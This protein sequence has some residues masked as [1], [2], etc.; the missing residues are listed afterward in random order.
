M[1]CLAKERSVSTHSFSDITLNIMPSKS[2]NHFMNPKFMPNVGGMKK[3]L[4]ATS[5]DDPGQDA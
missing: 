2:K 4:G 3:R 1:R 5:L